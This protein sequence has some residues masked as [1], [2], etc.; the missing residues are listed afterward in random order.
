LHEFSIA[1][2]IWQSVL[3]AVYTHGVARACPPAAWRVRSVTVEIGDFNLI[4]EEQLS[5]WLQQLGE[6]D[7]S[8]GVELKA[9]RRPGRVRCKECGEEGAVER[10]EQDVGFVAVTLPAC[11]KCGSRNLEVIGGRELRVV[12]AEVVQEESDGGGE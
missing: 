9:K 7:G 5:F 6:R 11:L 4:E 2:E 1:S 3:K 12:S 8:P 10:R